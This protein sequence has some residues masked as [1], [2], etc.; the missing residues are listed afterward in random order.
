[1]P[2]KGGVLK[3][4]VHGRMLLYI[5][6][7]GLAVIFS[8]LLLWYFDPL[9]LEGFQARSYRISSP[10]VYSGI[11]GSRQ[12]S[13]TVTQAQAACDTAPGCVGFLYYAGIAYLNTGETLRTPT[14]GGTYDTATNDL[15]FTLP[16]KN[17]VQTVVVNAQRRYVRVGISRTSPD[18]YVGIDQVVVTDENGNN[19]A[20][21]KRAT[22]TGSYPGTSPNEKTIDGTTSG[23]AYPNVWYSGNS[24]NDYWELDLGTP[25]KIRSITIY[26]PTDDRVDR[27]IG[28]PITV[29]MN[30]AGVSYSDW[31]VLGT[32]PSRGI[33]TLSGSGIDQTIT[34]NYVG[35][36]VRIRP[37]LYSGWGDGNVSLSSIIVRDQAGNNLSIGKPIYSTSVWPGNPPA[38][39]LVDGKTTPSRNTGFAS[40]NRESEYI[41]IDLGSEVYVATI[42][43][44]GGSDCCFPGQGG[45]VSDRQKGLRMIVS[46]TTS[47]EAAAAYASAVLYR[48]IVPVEVPVPIAPVQP[49]IEVRPA[50]PRPEIAVMAQ[51]IPIQPLRPLVERGP[52]GIQREVA[53]MSQPDAIPLRRVETTVAEKAKSFWDLVYKVDTEMDPVT[54]DRV[55]RVSDPD[56]NDMNDLMPLKFSKYIS[57]YA[58]SQHGDLSGA[59]QALFNNYN[60]MQSGLSKNVYTAPPEGTDLKAR[61]CANLD[62]ARNSYTTKYNQVVAATQDL[63]GMAI[64]AGAMREENLAYQNANFEA[65]KGDNRSPACISLASQE[66][67]IFSLLAKYENVNNTL[68]TSGAIDISNNL[69]VINTAYRFLGC[70]GAP[71][72]FSQDLA[73]TIDTQTLVSQLNQMSPYYLSPDTLQY[74][75]ASIISGPETDKNLMTDAEILI[76]ISRVISNIKTMTGAS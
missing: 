19:A 4:L 24:R 47:N 57:I 42:R 72:K 1:M 50:A 9:E 7:F 25:T 18:G 34:P 17:L 54:I 55:S 67:P 21:G 73:V 45:Y 6:I 74:I 60:T 2:L 63:S 31:A 64:K 11:G 32:D 62:A 66:G 40:G 35:R 58:L 3:L 65:C 20:L 46:S 27:I 61:S 39:Q 33:F 12:I 37:T 69:N 13:G 48:V 29:S 15:T 41:E 75:T 59:R 36:Y 16:N 53:V 51:P 28:V 8:V 23:R 49:I 10:A 22:A 44:L 5:L 30:T 71:L 76:N 68:A 26:H 14:A 52:G 43:I 70:A 38:T 56:P